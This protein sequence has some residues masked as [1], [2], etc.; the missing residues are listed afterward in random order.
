MVGPRAFLRLVRFYNGRFFEP[1]TNG[2]TA[3]GKWLDITADG[4][5]VLS[6]ESPRDRPSGGP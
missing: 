6:L 1:V 2:L 3:L 5:L 4:T